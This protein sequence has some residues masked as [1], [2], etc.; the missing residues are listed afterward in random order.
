MPSTHKVIVLCKGDHS[1]VVPG[2]ISLASGDSVMFKALRGEVTLEFH[3]AKMFRYSTIT[4]QPGTPQQL[5]YQGGVTPD[6]YYYDAMYSEAGRT[7]RAH[8]S[9]S[10][11]IIIEDP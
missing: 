11:S 3:N 2:T 7:Y 4:L 5:T 9:S 8:G 1:K 6:E 10:P